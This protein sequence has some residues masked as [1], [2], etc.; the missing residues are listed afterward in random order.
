MVSL[1]NLQ[2]KYFK[3]CRE[4]IRAFKHSHSL[5][6]DRGPQFFSMCEESEHAGANTSFHRQQTASSQPC[7]PFKLFE[8]NGI[9]SPVLSLAPREGPRGC[10]M[11]PPLWNLRPVI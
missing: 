5:I 2:N 6:A 3:L 11:S 8:N 9:I 10:L 7:W 1:S 4:S